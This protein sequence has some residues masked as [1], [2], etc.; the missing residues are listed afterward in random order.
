M[1]GVVRAIEF[2]IDQDE[3]IGETGSV[4]EIGTPA[5]KFLLEELSDGTLQVTASVFD[6]KADGKVDTAD[7]R[8]IFF[9][10][11]GID[12][13]P[14]GKTWLQDL[15]ITEVRASDGEPYPKIQGTTLD[16]DGV[17][18]AFSE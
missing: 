7:I 13:N 3:R 5:I 4:Y 16:A 1:S 8:G 11:A 9:H 14:A 17:H 2:V 18:L 6:N 10:I 12:N 15:R